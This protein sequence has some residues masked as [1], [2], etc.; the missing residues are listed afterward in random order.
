MKFWS[1][2]YGDGHNAFTHARFEVMKRTEFPEARPKDIVAVTTVDGIVIK[3]Y[4]FPRSR[5]PS[6][7]DGATFANACD[8][9]EVYVCSEYLKS[10]KKLNA[11][12]IHEFIHVCE[13]LFYR[14]FLKPHPADCTNQATI[15]GER[16]P[17][18]LENLRYISYRAKRSGKRPSARAK[19][20][21]K[22]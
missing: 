20:A 7:C 13:A 4:A 21:R 8:P 16:L 3:I 9:V 18:M 17:E 10:P 1:G 5:M 19:S 15:L 12:L 2:N 14:E 11:L 22:K 6:D